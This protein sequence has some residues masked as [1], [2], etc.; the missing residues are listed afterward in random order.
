M[1]F[2]L[3]FA[4][5]AA[6]A[7]SMNSGALHAEDPRFGIQAH[8]S[9]PIGD[10]KDKV[11]SKAGA[12][13]GVHA[14]LDLGQGHVIRPRADYT[15]FPEATFPMATNKIKNLSAGV[16]YLYFLNRKPEGLYLTTGLSFNHWNVDSS[17]AASGGYPAGSSTFSSNKAGYAFGA[18]FNFNTTFGAEL[19]Y[20][21][22][23]QIRLG[24]G[25]DTPASMLQAGVTL[26][27]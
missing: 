6:T 5:A 7:L 2:L 13:L 12:G 16:D 4:L 25:F 11:D 24:Q 1:A 27:F 9:F 17:Y 10:L 14:T 22:S 26:R 15:F 3:R 20:L 18:G 8:G 21:T 23:R 19:R